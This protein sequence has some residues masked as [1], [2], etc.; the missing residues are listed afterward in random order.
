MSDDIN[1][2]DEESNIGDQAIRDT[3]NLLNMEVRNVDELG[4][5]KRALTV[6][7]TEIDHIMRTATVRDRFSGINN[8]IGKAPYYSNLEEDFV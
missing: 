8:I 3:V 6:L 5:L 4:A 1:W 2:L 7:S